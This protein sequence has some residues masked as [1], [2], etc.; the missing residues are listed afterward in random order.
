MNPAVH[1]RRL[2][3]AIRVPV[4]VVVLMVI[5]SAVISERVLDQLSKT[6]ATYLQGLASAYLDGLVASVTP[7]VLREDSWEIFDSIERLRP[8]TDD[9]L[10]SETVV[11]DRNDIVLA[12]SNP[13]TRETLRPLDAAFSGK[14]AGPGVS[15]DPETRSGYVRRAII[16]QNMHVGSIYAVFDVTSLLKERRR[17]LATLLATNS[18]VTALLG[19]VGFMTVR[20]MIRPMQV[21]ETH[22]VEAAG[23]SATLIGEQEFPSADGEAA[24]VY[25]AY[26][27]LV[28]S[29]TERQKLSRQLAEE[30]KLASLG[31]LASGM[32]HE[33][34][35]PLGGLMNAVDTLRRHGENRNV[36][37]KSI[38]LI[39]RGLL[40]IREVVEAA[41]ATYRPDRLSRPVEG[42]DFSDLKL[43]V[44][45]E[46]RRRQQ[47]LD[48]RMPGEL[49]ARPEW[50]AGPIRQAVLN[51][52][53]NAVAASPEGG[54]IGYTITVTDRHLQITVTDEG[55][56]MPEAARRILEQGTSADPAEGEGLGLWIV[57]E[58]ANDLDARV[59]VSA[60]A[61][62]GTEVQLT[63]PCRTNEVSHAA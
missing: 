23:G 21:L 18:L 59:R 50:P 19:F 56:G 28:N 29:E 4:L 37:E 14:F 61:R 24:S 17:I 52:L 58:I 26:N 7:S 54:R 11:T 38:E 12:S 16:Y 40:G 32:A 35:N 5:I 53:L 6:Q 13:R 15:I 55:E 45:P 51:L 27:A 34:N 62:R 41:L 8:T 1:F 63:L 10:P 60:G 39:Q 48:F 20:R 31:R 9:I 46:L 42:S 30:E 22:L 25:R 33:I 49:P 36:R 57:R 2:P 47:A 44:R 3:S 43:L